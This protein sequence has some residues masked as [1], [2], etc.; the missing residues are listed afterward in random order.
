MHK[1]S[2]NEAGTQK[3][4]RTLVYHLSP[5][6]TQAMAGYSRPSCNGAMFLSPTNNSTPQTYDSM[7]MN[8]LER[9]QDHLDSLGLTEQALVSSHSLDDTHVQDFTAL[10]AA[11]NAWREEYNQIPSNIR[12]SSQCEYL[13]QIKLLS[14]QIEFKLESC[15]SRIQKLREAQN[16]SWRN[17]FRRAFP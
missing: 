17:R 9:A 8:L 10:K 5:P 12:K 4:P 16:R 14:S 7:F 11:W 3:P 2:T 6:K 13:R 15:N 1:S